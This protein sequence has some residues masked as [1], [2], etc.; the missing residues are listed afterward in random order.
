MPPPSPHPT[1]F[2]SC[3]QGQDFTALAILERLKFKNFSC[4]STIVADIP[5]QC[6]IALHFEIHFAGPLITTLADLLIGDSALLLYF[7]ET[8]RRS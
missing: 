1:I 2:R 4:Q 8:R 6:P 3:H 7:S 5:F